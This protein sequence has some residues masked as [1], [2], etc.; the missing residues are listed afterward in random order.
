MTTKE[1]F[2]SSLQRLYVILG[3]I[4]LIFLFG[5]LNERNVKH[6]LNDYLVSGGLAAALFLF[7]YFLTKN[8][9]LEIQN[10]RVL[11]NSGYRDIG[12]DTIDIFY[13]KYIYRAPAFIWRS[14]GSLMLIYARDEK[15][16]LKYSALR[17][18][19][20]SNDTLKR[21]LRRVKQIN[22]SIELDREYLDFLA[23]KYD[24]EYRSFGAWVPSK[25][26]IASVEARLREKGEKWD[27][28]SPLGRFLAKKS[29]KK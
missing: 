28:V 15:G 20:Y 5:I 22:P 2:G 26:T 12:S 14:G 7:V 19:N 29:K 11:K 18:V 3:A 8:T 4:A 10:Q 23:G 16:H 6:T 9:F 25:N 17:E 21:F 24:Y 27:T 1:R 13:I